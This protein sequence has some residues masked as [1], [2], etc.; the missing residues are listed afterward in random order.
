MLKYPRIV[1][2]DEVTLNDLQ[3]ILINYY[4]EHFTI[5]ETLNEVDKSIKDK[6]TNKDNTVDFYTEEELKKVKNILS[7]MLKRID[8]S[9]V[10]LMNLRDRD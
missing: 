5:I 6:I 1:Y 3:L 8:M 2:K 9:A 10:D 4:Y 7:E